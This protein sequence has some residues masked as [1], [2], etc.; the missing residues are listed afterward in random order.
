MKSL[1][2]RSQRSQHGFTVIE[3]LI[4][5]VIVGVVV[6][7]I[8]GGTLVFRDHSSGSEISGV[9]MGIKKEGIKWQTPEGYLNRGAAGADGTGGNVTMNEFRFSATEAAIPKLQE[10]ARTGQRVTL[11]YNKVRWAWS[12]EGDTRIF[13]Y[14]VIFPTAQQPPRES[15]AGR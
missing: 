12:W 5:V 2:R 4:V 9:V 3:L 11:V 8:A 7:L 1:N 13:V 15:G 14:D 10:A 6:A